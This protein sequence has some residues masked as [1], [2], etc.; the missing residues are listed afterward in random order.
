MKE[1]FTSGIL[2]DPDLPLP[3]KGEEG[4][5][6]LK[7]WTEGEDTAGGEGAKVGRVGLI[8]TKLSPGPARPQP[9]AVAQG[10]AQVLQRWQGE[11]DAVDLERPIRTVPLD[12]PSVLLTQAHEWT[13]PAAP[14]HGAFSR[15]R[16]VWAG[17]G[18]ALWREFHKLQNLSFGPALF[19]GP[20][21]RDH[22]VTWETPGEKEESSVVTRYAPPL[23][24]LDPLNG[25]EEMWFH[26]A[27]L[28]KGRETPVALDA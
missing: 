21:A 9:P 18:A 4:G 5:Q 1:K 17:G 11:R 10:G 19:E 27:V 6:L 2:R 14:Y 12:L 28:P 13:P 16:V 23:L 7:V 3:W 15:L 25:T 8:Q 22:P 26:G 20:N 24:C